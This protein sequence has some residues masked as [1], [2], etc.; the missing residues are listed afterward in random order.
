MKRKSVYLVAFAALSATA[1]GSAYA[2]NVMEN[3]A[4]AIQT[5]KIGLT[6][7]VAVAEQHVVGKASRAEFEKNKGQW[8]YDVE[9][10]GDKKVMDVKVDP[11]SGKVFAAT[12]DKADKHDKEE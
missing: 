4:M 11:E 7:A 12:E 1:M 2:S 10:V 9:V 8:V 6:Q 5:A 3:D